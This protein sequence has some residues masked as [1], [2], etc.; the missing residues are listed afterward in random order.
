MQRVKGTQRSYSA[1]LC[2]LSDFALRYPVRRCFSRR[3][4]C[5]LA[6]RSEAGACDSNEANRN[7]NRDNF[8]ELNSAQR[9]R[10][11]RVLPIRGISGK[12]STESINK[13]DCHKSIT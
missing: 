10:F 1:K 6:T 12:I 13:N 3:L 9:E 5:G 11:I 2:G 4:I 8:M 7:G